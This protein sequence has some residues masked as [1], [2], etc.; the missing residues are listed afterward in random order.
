MKYSLAIDIGASSGRH[1]LGT[2]DNGKIVLEEMYRF[3]NVQIRKNGHDC[4]DIETLVS[5]VIAGIKS[6]VDAGKAPSTIGIDTW[7]VDFVL[8]DS[9]LKLCS[10]AVAYRDERTKGIDEDAAKIIS[11]KNL[12]S[13]TGIQKLPFNSIYQLVALKKKSPEQLEKAEHFL[14]IPDYLNF[15]LTGKI[16][17]EYTN[18]TTTNLVN[19]ESKDWDYELI[20]RLGLP[21]KIFGSLNMPGTVVGDLLPEIA[22]ETKS[23]AK[24]ILPATHDTGSAFLA[25]PA[26]DEKTVFLSSGTWSL[27]G[28]ENKIPITNDYAYNANFTNEGGAWYRFRFLKNI[29]GLWMIQSIRRE[30]NGVEY[31]SGKSKKTE[32]VKERIDDLEELLSHGKI[33]FAQLEREA[34]KNVD[35]KSVID[36]NDNRF[37]DPQSMISEVCRACEEKGVCV[38]K[39]VGEL[40][41]CVYISLAKC[42]AEKIIELSK[43]TGVKY[44]SLNIVGGGSQDG[45]LNE[46]VKRETHLDVFAGPIEGT[47][48]GNLAIQFI[49]AKE[50]SDITE[51]RKAIRSSFNVKEI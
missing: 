32:D 29:M 15:R 5:H 34:R 19:S 2:I 47:A 4:W 45:Y 23:N 8:L 24:V 51:F 7:G 11:L 25:V 37:L 50:F 1:I 17:N 21:K 6:C 42:Y 12:Y 30:L 3:D 39:T 16:C 10:D 31:V 46:L 27:L 40:M 44:T 48:I 26:R 22:K 38:P 20:E 18:S 13:R 36:V 9:D 49:A 43:I 33:S 14:M 41:Q 28:V 35:F